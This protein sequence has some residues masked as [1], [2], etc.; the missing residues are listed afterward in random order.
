MQIREAHIQGHLVRYREAGHASDGTSPL[1][2]LHGIAGSSE[3]WAEV[4]DRLGRDRPVIAP[5]LLGHGES[6]KPRAD[7]SLGA[8]AS[9][10]RDLLNMLGHERATI[11]G[12]SL[13]GG[14]ALQFAYLFPERCERLVLVAS[15]GLGAEVSLPLRAASLP[16]SE[17]VLPVILHR[18]VI[19]VGRAIH[20]TLG[21]VG[22]R[23]TRA[24][25]Q[26]WVTCERLATTP[27]RSAFLHTLRSTVDVR[28][29]R[30]S[31]I[32]RLHLLSHVPVMLAWG[33]QDR[34]IPVEH[35]R[36][37][38]AVL[39]HAELVTF[40]GVGHFPHREVPE[41]FAATVTDF[42]SGSEPSPADIARQAM[43]ETAGG[44]DESGTA[45]PGSARPAYT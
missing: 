20:R 43:P 8:Y 34:I 24:A 7:Y 2:L 23:P 12:H 35:G 41:D 16:G 3:D 40:P 42:V 10:V 32:D 28:G 29:Q 30:V 33:E 27:A 19:E 44:T 25:A 14:I 5:D 45:S 21:R 6:A 4:L 18:R 31:A 36:R 1:V 39:P 26:T 11:V 37:A 22:L 9:S 15:G 38:T 13:G 17:L